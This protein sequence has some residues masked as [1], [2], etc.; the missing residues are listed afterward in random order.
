LIAKSAAL[1]ILVLMKQF[2]ACH[3]YQFE[4]LCKTMLDANGMLLYLKIL[5]QDFEKALKT[6]SEIRLFNLSEQ[7][8]L[9]DGELRDS[10]RLEA[11]LL[12]TS[13]SNSAAN[14]D[15]TAGDVELDSTGASGGGGNVHAGNPFEVINMVIYQSHVNYMRILQ[16]IVK[17]KEHRISQMIQLKSVIVLRKILKFDDSMIQRYALKLIKTQVPFMGRKFRLSNMPVFS[18]FFAHARPELVLDPTQ[19]LENGL[20]DA[21]KIFVRDTMV[22]VVVISEIIL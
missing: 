8:R 2:K 7:C 13:S 11:D 5:N 10:K 1:L 3:V 6:R 14:D 9:S 21:E 15:V 20:N 4:N 16:K 19:T 12:L 18:G 17:N 22:I